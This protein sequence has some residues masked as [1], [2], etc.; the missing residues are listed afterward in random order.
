MSRFIGNVDDFSKPGEP[1][2]L[3]IA[4]DLLDELGVT[5]CERDDQQRA[6]DRWLTRNTPNKVLAFSLRRAGFLAENVSNI[7][8]NEPRRTGPDGAGS[9]A[10]VSAGNPHD[11]GRRRTGRHRGGPG[12]SVS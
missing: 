12:S 3:A 9:T 10:G 5:D 6:V 7:L 11:S 8:S 4:P 1:R 2:L